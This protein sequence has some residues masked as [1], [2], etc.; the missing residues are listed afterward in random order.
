MQD[1]G[2]ISAEEAEEKQM[3]IDKQYW[4][5]LAAYLSGNLSDEKADGERWKNLYGEDKR[6]YNESRRIWENSGMRLD[7]KHENTDQEWSKLRSRIER[8]KTPK[9]RIIELVNSNSVWLKAAAGV[10]LLAGA[11]YIFMDSGSMG[12]S[13][14][15]AVAEE[16]ER[17]TITAGD[18][19]LSVFLPDSTKVWLNSQST[20]QY[21]EV[22]GEGE[23]K[24]WLSGEAYFAVRRDTAAPFTVTVDQAVVRVLGTS[25]NVREGQGNVAVTVAEGKVQVA[26]SDEPTAEKVELQAREKAVLTG[27]GALTKAVNDDPRFADWRKSNNPVYENEKLKP[28]GYLDNTYSWEKNKINLSVIQGRIKNTAE[29][30]SYRNIVLRASYTKP[31]GKKSA[32]TFTIEEKIE[33]GEYVFYQKRLLDIFTDTRKVRVEVVSAEVVK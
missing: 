22:F 6:V 28:S 33:P 3:K 2:F 23:R 4:K 30:A 1:R 21:T 8:S 26:V 29:L 17:L 32:T 5:K 16:P 10:I 27:A 11:F 24:T 13:E 14:Y 31:S 25:F 15:T 18:E 19:V 7:M 9:G 12:D 20:L